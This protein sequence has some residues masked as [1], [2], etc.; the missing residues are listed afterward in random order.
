M[1]PLSDPRSLGEPG[2]SRPAPRQSHRGLQ[3]ERGG[4]AAVA[5]QLFGWRRPGRAPE[6]AR[7]PRLRPVLLAA[8][9]SATAPRPSAG[10]HPEHLI[11]NYHSQVPTL[12]H[13]TPSLHPRLRRSLQLRSTAPVPRH[14]SAL[15][16]PGHKPAC[17]CHSATPRRQPP[18]R[19]VNCLQSPWPRHAGSLH[20]RKSLQSACVHRTHTHLHNTPAPASANTQ[21]QHVHRRRTTQTHTHMPNT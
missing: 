8:S 20:H 13:S 2:R 6:A 10:G 9:S 19:N 3:G 11:L 4:E 14:T 16:G 15:Q 1:G 5:F 21:S 18:L 7:P 17:L 12:P